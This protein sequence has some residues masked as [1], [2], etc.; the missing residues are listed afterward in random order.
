M[1]S[2]PSVVD[3]VSRYASHVAFSYPRFDPIRAHE[4]AGLKVEVSV[5]SQFEDADDV[6]EWTVRVHGIILDINDGK[7]S[8]T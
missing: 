5:L 8:A 3:A 7:L 4:L 2:A 6:Y 1:K